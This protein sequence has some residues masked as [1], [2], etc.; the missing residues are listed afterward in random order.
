MRKNIKIL[1][2]KYEEI[3]EFEIIY[4]QHQIFCLFKAIEQ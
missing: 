4:N 3:D 1:R 2:K